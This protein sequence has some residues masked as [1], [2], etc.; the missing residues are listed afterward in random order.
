MEYPA[1]SPLAMIIR[2][3]LGTLPAPPI[4]A[5][6]PTISASL[7]RPRMVGRIWNGSYNFT[8]SAA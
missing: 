1:P 6:V 7:T 5:K 4:R 8:L 3:I 2:E